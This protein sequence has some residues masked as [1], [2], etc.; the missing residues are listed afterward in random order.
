MLTRWGAINPVARNPPVD[1]L[2]RP[3]QISIRC[4]V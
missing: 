2:A 4:C 1:T 3:W